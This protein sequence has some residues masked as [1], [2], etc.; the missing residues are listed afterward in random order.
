MI[1]LTLGKAIRERRKQIG[2][3]QAQL[4][5][6][7][8][9]GRVRISEWESGE[10]PGIEARSIAKLEQALQFEPGELFLIYRAA[11]Q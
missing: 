10:T 11:N 9:F 4:A 8:G 5:E 2:L 6:K 7:T 1:C 3:T